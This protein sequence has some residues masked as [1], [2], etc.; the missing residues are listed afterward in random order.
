MLLKICPTCLGDMTVEEIPGGV[1]GL[2]VMCGY[3]L[4][5]EA[6]PSGLARNQSPGLMTTTQRD[7]PYPSRQ[8][9]PDR[10]VRAT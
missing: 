6:R 8:L 10:L 9:R 4:S 1:D 3:G 2:C 7:W 5:A